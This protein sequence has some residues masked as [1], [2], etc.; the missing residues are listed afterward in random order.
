MFANPSGAVYGTIAVAALLAAESA[1]HETYLETVSAVVITLILYW[2]AHSYAE[3][4]GERL[5]SGE[6]LTAS[7]LAHTMAREVTI[8]FGAAV[9]LIPLL[10]WWL[11][12]GQLT[13]AVTAAVWT[14]A[15]T[16]VVTELLV[17]LRAELSGRRLVAQ[18]GI[19]ALL[20]LLVI[21][22]KVVLH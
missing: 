20:G 8:L 5:R 7:G 2:L 3:F 4:T 21:A 14:S 22:L 12:G 19:G 9:P 16:I 17:G 1:R 10:V 15:V 18:A 13:G 6:R 11:T